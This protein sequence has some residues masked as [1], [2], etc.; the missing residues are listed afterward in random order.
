M[1][2]FIFRVLIVYATL[3]FLWKFREKEISKKSLITAVAIAAAFMIAS[4]ILDY[5]VMFIKM[6]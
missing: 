1:I 6:D 3:I 2:V 4:F 5:S